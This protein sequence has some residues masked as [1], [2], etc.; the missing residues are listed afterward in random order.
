M[1]KLCAPAFIY[2]FISLVDII[3]NAYLGLYNNLLVKTIVI[4]SV[5]LF[6]TILCERG[7]SE[8]SWLIVLLSFIFIGMVLLNDMGCNIYYM[9][10]ATMPS[11]TTP[12]A[13]MPSATTSAATTSTATMPSATTSSAT[14]P[15][16]ISFKNSYKH[17]PSDTSD[18]QYKS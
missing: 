11:A 8:V 14:M 7:F 15:A 1:V 5:T 12:S 17:I 6:L 18:P 13:T 3:Y 4:I 10:S 9:P 16:F 2:L